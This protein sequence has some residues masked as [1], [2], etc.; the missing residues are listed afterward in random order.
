MVDFVPL[1]YTYALYIGD[2][3]EMSEVFEAL[4]E[5]GVVTNEHL[6]DPNIGWPKK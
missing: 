4:G 5:D 6:A 3:D 2:T 1:E